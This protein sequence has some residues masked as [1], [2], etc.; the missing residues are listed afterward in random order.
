MI[1]IFHNYQ[2]TTLITGS[3]HSKDGLYFIIEAIMYTE[4]AHQIN[5]HNSPFRF[6]PTNYYIILS[7]T[8]SSR[9]NVPLQQQN[10]RY[11]N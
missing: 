1:V 11:C 10:N 4:P 8:S 3:I 9:V 6:T 7:N 5:I 2:K